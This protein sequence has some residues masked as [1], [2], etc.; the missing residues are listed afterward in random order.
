MSAALSCLLV[1]I[2]H[3]T[4][5]SGGFLLL[6]SKVDE[7]PSGWLSQDDLVAAGARPVGDLFLAAEDGILQGQEPFLQQ[8]QSP[9]G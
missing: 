8:N 4:A 1:F 5:G 3:C 2:L 7:F 9:S 6:L